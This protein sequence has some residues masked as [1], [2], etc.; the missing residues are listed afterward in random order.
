MN[1]LTEN[2]RK[3]IILHRKD[4]RFRT[5]VMALGC[6]VVFVTTYMLIYPALALGKGKR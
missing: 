3:Y 5:A 6:L 4:R 2:I 1:R